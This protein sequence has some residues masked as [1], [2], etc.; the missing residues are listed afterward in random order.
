M[1]SAFLRFVESLSP[2]TSTSVV[3]LAL[4]M[5]VTV[6]YL[7]R[8]ALIFR[9][10]G[11]MASQLRGLKAALRS[12]HIRRENNKVIVSGFHGEWPA[13]LRFSKDET[14]CD[15]NLRLSVPSNLSLSVLPR[16]ATRGSEKVLMP[17]D[18]P[19][20]NR[21]FAVRTDD[22]RQAR[23][24]LSHEESLAEIK[25]LC[26]TSQ[27]M[28]TLRSGAIN[29]SERIPNVDNLARRLANRLDSVTVLARLAARM[30]GS[31]RI[32]LE[33]LPRWGVFTSLKVSSCL[34]ALAI[35]WLCFALDRAPNSVP[36]GGG[37]SDILTLSGF[38]G[39]HLA[40]DG[41]FDD[42]FAYRLMRSNVPLAAHI[43]LRT[44][45]P[46]ESAD[47]FFLVSKDGSRRVAIRIKGTI[48][49]DSRFVHLAGIVRVPQER[50]GDVD[51]A[52]SAAPSEPVESDGLMLVPDAGDISRAS[53]LF[54]T[55][56]HIHSGMPGDYRDVKLQSKVSVRATHLFDK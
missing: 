47:A 45:Q 22:P 23:L 11:Q 31:Y 52:A 37:V 39:W 9:G 26:S 38:Q 42:R 25:K 35:G 41:A 43:E 40:D 54:F 34:I 53:I 20:L 55:E 28:L 24:F 29:F 48:L 6:I 32:K 19:A 5:L 21:R 27:A 30:T 16:T 4:L 49:Y 12:S 8:Q 33:P 50:M 3:L 17:T 14:T 18:D 51:W 10:Y 36:S 13:I 44:D 7:I 56:G 2:A 46:H 1:V 15:V